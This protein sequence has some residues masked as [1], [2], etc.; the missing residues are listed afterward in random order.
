MT[1]FRADGNG[2]WA[3]AGVLWKCAECRPVFEDDDDDK[4]DGVGDA[5]VAF[6]WFPLLL[7]LL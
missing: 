5:V 4:C 6:E 1:K 7:L 2:D 3:E